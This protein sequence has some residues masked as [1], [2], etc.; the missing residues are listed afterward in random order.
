M[1]LQ[2]AAGRRDGVRPQVVVAAI[3][4]AASIPGSAI[5]R[6]DINDAMTFV[7]VRQECADDVMALPRLS[8]GGRNVTAQPA[9]TRSRPRVARSPGRPD[10]PS[11]RKGPRR[12]K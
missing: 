3:A 4:T 7:D 8:L 9:G 6:I 11:F 1:T 10:R 2:L 5:G 12:G